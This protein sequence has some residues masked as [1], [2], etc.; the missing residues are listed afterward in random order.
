MAISNPKHYGSKSATQK[1]P[2]YQA[3]LLSPGMNSQT[4]TTNARGP[5]S[6]TWIG[7]DPYNTLGRISREFPA[8]TRRTGIGN[9]RRG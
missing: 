2:K 1:P 6:Q 4:Y 8:T 3:H 9:G 5:S 7:K